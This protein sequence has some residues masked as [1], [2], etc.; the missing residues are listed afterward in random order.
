M[1]EQGT[2][3]I[4]TEQQGAAVVEFMDRNI[5]DEV[6]IAQLGEQLGALADQGPRP[7]VILDFANVA[8]MSSSALGMLI[9]LHKRIK[10]RHGQLRL[11]HIRPEIYEVFIITKLNEIFH[12]HDDRADALASFS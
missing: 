2:R 11:C 10:E 1:Q 9:T 7:R 8:H 6:N 12:I 5:L 3:I 4:T